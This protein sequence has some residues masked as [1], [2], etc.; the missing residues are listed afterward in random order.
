[1]EEVEEELYVEFEKATITKRDD[2]LL[3][4]YEMMEKQES[5]IAQMK[6]KMENMQE[7]AELFL[8]KIYQ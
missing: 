4:A 3:Q 7:D 1:M 5:E 6:L 8:S 2:P